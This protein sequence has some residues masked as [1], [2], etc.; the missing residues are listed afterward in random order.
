M[1]EWKPLPK[2]DEQ[3]LVPECIPLPEDKDPDLLIPESIPLPS[4]D[5]LD[6][7]PDLQDGDD[8]DLAP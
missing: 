2:D 5:D 1:P 8:L 3:S 7:L 6:L 4:D